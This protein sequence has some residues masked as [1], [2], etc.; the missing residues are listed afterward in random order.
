MEQTKFISKVP[1]G[2]SKLSFFGQNLIAGNVL[3]G[4]HLLNED[5][6]ILKRIDIPFGV[7]DMVLTKDGLLKR[8][9]D[10]VLQQ[11]CKAV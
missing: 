6:T 1:E 3:N 5:Y 4:Y 7:L 11:L 10:S 2:I 8:N 9:R